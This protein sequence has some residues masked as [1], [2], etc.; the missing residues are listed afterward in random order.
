M[1]D[2]SVFALQVAD[3]VNGHFPS[4]GQYSWH[5]WNHPGPIA[6][7]LFAPLHWIMAGTP[8]ATFVGAAVWN[9]VFGCL[10]VRTA[11]RRHPLGGYAVVVI[12]CASWF[13][14]GRLSASDPWTPYLALPVF[15]WFLAGVWGTIERDRSAVWALC[16]STAV[17]VQVHVGY[18]PITSV[19]GLTALVLYWR[20]GGAVTQLTRPIV[21]AAALFLPWLFHPIEVV[22][23]LGD[24]GRFFTSSGTEAVGFGRGFRILVAEMSPTAAWLGG[25]RETGVI[26]EAPG[27]SVIWIAVVLAVLVGSV[28]AA[29]RSPRLWTSTPVVVVALLVSLV[30]VAQ[31]RGF[32]FPYVVMFRTPVAVAVLLWCLVALVTSVGGRHRGVVAVM[33]VAAVVSTAVPMVSGLRHDTVTDDAAAV[34]DVALIARQKVVTSPLLVRL[35]DGGL[36]GVYPELVRSFEHWGI[37]SGVEVGTEWVFGAR[38]IHGDSANEVWFVCD[39]GYAFSILSSQPGARVVAEHTPF[40]P[41]QESTVVSMQVDLADGLRELGRSDLLSALD[42][43]LVSFALGDLDL[44]PVTLSELGVLNSLTPEPGDRFGIVAFP[45]DRQPETWWSLRPVDNG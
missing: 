5:G 26:G 40:S 20:G 39:T 1:G 19:V 6:F 34:H 42:S 21:G 15:V 11:S 44:D 45:V 17:L 30:A 25:P 12:L 8:A 29:R 9:T 23:N 10:A 22:H 27:V 24:L 16:L 38:S 31:V 35:G 3:V 18:L 37:D 33:A 32:V 4:L 28:F 14:A 2:R 36:V 7:Y 13:P 43:P 41:E